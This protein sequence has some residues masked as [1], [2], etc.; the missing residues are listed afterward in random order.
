MAAL[1]EEKKDD[2]ENDRNNR[3]EI[4]ER[5]NEQPPSS[6]LLFL[7]ETSVKVAIHEGN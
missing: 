6:Q 2:W 3:K 1:Q 5:V 4:N 7:C